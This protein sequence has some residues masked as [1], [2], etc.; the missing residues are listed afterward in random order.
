MLNTKK[1]NIIRKK[2][3]S[4]S[5]QSIYGLLMC[6]ILM[7][8]SL[9]IDSLPL[10]HFLTNFEYFKVMAVEAKSYKGA[11]CKIKYMANLPVERFII[12]EVAK[13]EVF[14]LRKNTFQQKNKQFVCW[15]TKADG[16]GQTYFDQQSLLLNKSLTLYA[17]YQQLN[18]WSYEEGKLYYYQNQQRQ[19]SGWTNIEQHWYYLD[20]STGQVAT[21]GF[22]QLP[23][24]PFLASITNKE[25]LQTTNLQQAYFLFDEK[26]M[27]QT[28]TTGLYRVESNRVVTNKKVR[29]LK[30]RTNIWLKKGRVEAYPGLVCQNQNYYYFPKNYFEQLLAE[31]RTTGMITDQLY[32]VSKTNSLAYPQS[33]AS[34]EFQQGTYYFNQKGELQF[35]EGILR[36]KHHLYYFSRGCKSYAGL[37]RIKQSYYYVNSSGE[38]LSN[39]QFFIHKTNQLLPQGYYSFNHRGQ[40]QLRNHEQIDELSRSDENMPASTL[41]Q[42]GLLQRGGSYYYIDLQGKLIRNQDYYIA[43]TNGLLPAKSYH[44]DLNGKLIEMGQ[45]IN[46]IV[47]ENEIDWYYYENGLKVY[48][49]LIEIDGNYYYVN[50]ECK[51]I[52][53]Q[54]YYISKTNQLLLQDTY[55]FNQQG[56]LIQKDEQKTG[57]VK[58]T[59]GNWYY[60]QNGLKVYAGLI[61]ID[62]SYYY[63]NS[64]FQ[65]LHDTIAYISKTNQLLPPGEYRFDRQ[66]R[67]DLNRKK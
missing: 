13:N 12:Q 53:N 16:S 46:G 63:V 32:S 67:V 20:P 10:V 60:Y 22:Y 7:L 47:K 51:V 28:E 14:Q 61:E 65:V 55:E 43:Q 56:V 57:I 42:S 54:N 31:K 34:G 45:K 50:S 41:C 21:Q 6:F 48:A 18:G 25:N 64:H 19:K 15:N 11:V 26:G 30:Q 8:V 36:Y 29:Y 35:L 5:V 44:F 66:G 24:P 27:L 39:G 40:L 4:H 3:R 17:Q 58:A 59:D 23:Y 1:T 37:V 38:L 9:Y 52:H 49:G 62:G 33:V 2:Q